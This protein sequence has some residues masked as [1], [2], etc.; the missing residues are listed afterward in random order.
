MTF[1]ERLSGLREYLSHMFFETDVWPEGLITFYLKENGGIYF[2]IHELT[3]QI[4]FKQMVR[5]NFDAPSTLTG[6]PYYYK[7]LSLEEF[8]DILPT[9]AQTELLFHL[10]LFR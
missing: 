1:D 4:Y 6:L 5:L 2:L 8:I 9:T 7:E 10:D 3:G